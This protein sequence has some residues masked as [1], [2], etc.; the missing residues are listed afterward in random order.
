MLCGATIAE[1]EHVP[2]LADVLRRIAADKSRA[3]PLVLSDLLHLRPS[4]CG[5]DGRLYRTRTAAE[6]MAT[7]YA[8]SVSELRPRARLYWRT[9]PDESRWRWWAVLLP[10]GDENEEP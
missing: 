5:S 8:E 9:V 2:V 6:Q 7:T 4:Q 1:V 10:E 3:D